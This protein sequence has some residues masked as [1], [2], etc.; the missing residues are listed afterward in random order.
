[1]TDAAHLTPMSSP[2][3]KAPCYE[4]PAPSK[5]FARAHPN[6]TFCASFANGY[7]R[8]RKGTCYLTDEQDPAQ[9]SLL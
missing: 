9:G 5:E 7:E 8:C 6:W 1:V 4:L 3:D 2:A